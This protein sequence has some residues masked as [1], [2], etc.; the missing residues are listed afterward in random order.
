MVYEANNSKKLTSL[1]SSKCK[2]TSFV[3]GLQKEMLWSSNR[4]TSLYYL[5]LL[6]KFEGHTVSYRQCFS[7]PI[8]GP[9]TKYDRGPGIEVEITR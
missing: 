5:P 9:V 4:T 7:T 2:P 8:Y 6:I 1:I 3:L